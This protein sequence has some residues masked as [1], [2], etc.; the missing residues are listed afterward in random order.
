MKSASLNPREERRLMR[1]HLWAYR[2]EF[3]NLPDLEDGDLVDIFSS[4]RRFV[5]RGFFQQDGGIAVRLLSRHQEEINGPFFSER[6]AQARH[7]RERLFPGS[8]VWR[9]IHAESDGLPGLVADRYERQVFV[10]TACAFYA[11]HAE[12]LAGIFLQQDGVSGVRFVGGTETQVFGDAPDS[13]EFELEGIIT[14]LTFD[15]AQ[16]T[17]LFL[18]QRI[19]RLCAGHF[20]PG[21]RV[22]DGHCYLGQWSCHAARAGAL[23][24]LGVDTSSWAIEEARANAVRNGVDSQ[25]HF[26]CA[27]VEDVLERGALF[28][29]VILDP[30]AFAKG[31]NQADKALSRYQALNTNAMRCV[32]PGGVLITSSCSHFVEPS[33]FLDMLKRAAA[34]A[35]RQ[36]LLIELRGAA[37]DHP[38]LLSM[39]ETAYLKCAVLQLG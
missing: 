31:R 6:V 1:G 25:C 18:D 23:S 29:V 21:A 39:P 22:L 30:P 10:K 19:N 32:T 36:A 16:K 27:A 24:V 3:K 13:V 20:S 26:E 9:W 35:R 11:R 28:D 5:G 38:V 15:G 12:E 2:N 34:A 14:R 33:G 37:P 17:G 4:E 7:L 8:T